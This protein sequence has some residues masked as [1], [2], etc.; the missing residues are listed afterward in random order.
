M[1]NLILKRILKQ[2]YSLNVPKSLILLSILTLPLVIP[3]F[4]I[5]IVFQLAK[6]FGSLA[7]LY[8]SLAFVLYL[9]LYGISHLPKSEFRRWL[10]IFTRIYIRFHIAL[11][12][13]GVLLIFL[14]VTLMLNIIPLNTKHTLS[15]LLT[16]MTLVVVIFTGYLRKLKSSGRRRRYHRYISFLFIIFLI[17]HILI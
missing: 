4:K 1:F 8:F 10:V 3:L 9:F 6:T 2:L 7:A 15:G 16:I 5:P 12:I 17:I 14:H 11:A 13:V